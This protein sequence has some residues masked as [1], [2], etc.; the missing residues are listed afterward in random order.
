MFEAG[1]YRDKNDVLRA[2]LDLLEKD[3]A[4]RQEELAWL[5][6]EVQKGMDDIEAGRY[7]VLKSRE[8]ITAFG[9]E[10]SRRCLERLEREKHVPP[11]SAQ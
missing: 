4:E 8:E 5:K 9:K 11:A 2:A 1:R 6:A 10:I 3:E 7:T